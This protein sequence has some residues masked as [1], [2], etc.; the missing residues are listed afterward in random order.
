MSRRLLLSVGAALALA[1][2]AGRG[3]APAPAPAPEPDRPAALEAAREIIV[4][5]RYAALITT[6]PDG[7]PQAR[8]IDPFAPE[9]DFTVWFATNPLTR[10]VDEIRRDPRVVLY[11]FDPG[12]EGYVTLRGRARLVD[13]AA[14]RR[15]R[16]KPE[17][18]PF[19]PDRERGYLL[20]AVTPERMEIV[21]P[22]RGITGDAVTWRPPTLRFP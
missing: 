2:C 6:G 9:P 20:V 10:K 22:R 17:W 8:T 16:W 7:V 11:W 13:D 3:A 18:E 5:A 21:S 4:G 1:A 19:Y 12:V 15:R 14:E